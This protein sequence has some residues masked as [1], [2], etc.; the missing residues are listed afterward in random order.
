[1]GAEERRMK[2]AAQV[3]SG[4]ITFYFNSYL[5]IPAS[6]KVLQQFWFFQ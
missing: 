2:A 3:L 4:D 1:M 6:Q 5:D